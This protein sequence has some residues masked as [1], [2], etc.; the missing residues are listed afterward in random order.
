[1]VTS[2]DFKNLTLKVEALESL[3][4]RLEQYREPDRQIWAELDDDY[5][6][7]ERI[8]RLHKGLA[9]DIANLG[10]RVQSLTGWAKRLD[11]ELEQLAT[12]ERVLKIHAAK[13]EH[14]Q[15]R[16]AKDEEKRLQNETN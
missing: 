16:T 10:Q 2:Q 14:E 4:S 11:T 3:V 13:Q 8:E 12:V 1:M 6:R 15:I 5:S 9:E 7:L